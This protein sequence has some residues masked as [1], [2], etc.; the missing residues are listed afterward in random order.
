[1]YRDEW[2]RQPAKFYE[3]LEA[4]LQDQVD[5]ALAEILKDPV[6]APHVKPLKGRFKGH[7]RR[8]IDKLRIVYRFDPKMQVLYVEVLDYRGSVYR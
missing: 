8:T 6:R 3:K 1:M 5:E 2:T 4:R 7:Y